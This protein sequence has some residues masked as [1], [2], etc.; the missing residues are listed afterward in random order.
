VLERKC[1]LHGG[2]L[3]LPRSKVSLFLRVRSRQLVTGAAETLPKT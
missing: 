3:A 1:A 2:A